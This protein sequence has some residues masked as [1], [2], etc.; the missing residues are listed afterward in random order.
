MILEQHSHHLFHVNSQQVH[1]IMPSTSAALIR[2]KSKF[3][4]NTF[5]VSSLYNNPY[6]FN[7]S[8]HKL[9]KKMKF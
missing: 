1:N 9:E 8:G 3:Q 5:T 7:D 6:Q 4:I 2:K